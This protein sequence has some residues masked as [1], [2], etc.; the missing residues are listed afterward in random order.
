ML[1]GTAC[2]PGTRSPGATQG[3]FDR[4]DTPDIRIEQVSAADTWLLRQQVLRPHE[5]V[6]DQAL[7]DDDAPLVASFAAI[8]SEGQIV[9]TARVAPEGPPTALVPQLPVDIHPSWRLRGMAA[10]ADIRGQGVGTQ[11]L[12]RCILHVAEHGGG[13]LW[14]NARI[15][16]I[17]LY[18]R[19]GF[20]EHGDRWVEPDIGP[21]VVMWR[22][23]E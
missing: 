15:G 23:V 12:Q 22:V 20:V 4:V 16:A 8:D 5:T 17:A 1:D 18:Q 21:H 19:A 3:Y 6:A 7:A 14:C 2:P 9:A 13:L 10:R 11:V